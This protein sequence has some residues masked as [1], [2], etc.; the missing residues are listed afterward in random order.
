MAVRENDF[1]QPVGDPVPEWSGAPYPPGAVLSGRLVVLRP[2]EAG[3]ADD[4]WAAWS[5]TSAADWTYLPMERPADLAGTRSVVDAMVA[6]PTTVAYVVL[7]AG[8][9]AGVLS[10]MRI[11]PTNGV[12]EIGAVILG[13]R[14]RRTAGSTEAQRL[15]MG[16]VLDDL[17]HRRLEWKCDALN[18]PSMAAAERLGY[19][20]EGVF[21]NAVVTKGRNRDTAWWSVTD[22]EWPEVRERLDAWLAPSNFDADGRQLRRLGPGTGA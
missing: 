15:L 3:D 16:H 7:V 5:G 19:T 18:G 21:R 17:G 10:L 9:A 13:T 11:D 14:L 1:G 22:G 6:D 8:A 4:L 20:F 2:L 12:V